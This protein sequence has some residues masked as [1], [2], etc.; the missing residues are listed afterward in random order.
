VGE[1][2]TDGVADTG[3]RFQVSQGSTKGLA[4][5]TSEEMPRVDPARFIGRVAKAF[6]TAQE[7]G[8]TLQIRLSPPELGAMRLELTVKDGVMAATLETENSS[9]KRVL[10]EHLPALRER[11]AEQNIRVD[12]FDVDVRREGAGGQADPRAAQDQQQPQHGH[13]ERRQPR[14]S[15]VSETSHRSSVLPTAQPQTT[16]SGINLVV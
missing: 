16:A 3:N 7:R 15:Q 1:T 4:R 8:G 5:T 6:H 11:L 2:K 13:S 12:R 14:A 9:A 10:L